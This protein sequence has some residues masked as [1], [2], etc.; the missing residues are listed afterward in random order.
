MS[1]SRPTERTPFVGAGFPP[2]V[3]L[4]AVPLLVAVPPDDD[5]PHPASSVAAAA[6]TAISRWDGRRGMRSV[7]VMLLAVGVGRA[8]R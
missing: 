5:P 7:M 4:A 2:A 8:G 6:A 1:P 3:E